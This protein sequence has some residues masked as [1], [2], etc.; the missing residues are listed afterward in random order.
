MVFIATGMGGGDRSAIPVIA[1]PEAGL[2]T[3]TVVTIPFK[4][5]GRS[6]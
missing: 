6:G 3:I 2:L 1:K 5:K 4:S